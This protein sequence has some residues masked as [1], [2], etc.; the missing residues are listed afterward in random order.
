MEMW[1]FENDG[2]LPRLFSIFTF[3]VVLG[4]MLVYSE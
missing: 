1:T 2:L 3:T 4:R